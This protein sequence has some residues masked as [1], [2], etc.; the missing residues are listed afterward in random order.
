MAVLKDSILRHQSG[1]SAG[2]AGEMPTLNDLPRADR[3]PITLSGGGHEH[4]SA[5]EIQRPVCAVN[6]VNLTGVRILLA[7]PQ[8]PQ[9]PA[10]GAARSTRT[11]C[12]MLA[13]AGAEVHAVA[14]WGCPPG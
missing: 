2:V 7:L 1:A 12:E 9:D 14:T 5:E 10:S 13:A 6:Q 8:L 4:E 3:F 11:M